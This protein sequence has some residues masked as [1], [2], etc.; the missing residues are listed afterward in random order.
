MPQKKKESLGGDKPGQEVQADH[1]LFLQAFEKPTQ[2]YRYLRS[3]NVLSPIFLQRTLY[4]MR[5]RMSRSHK[6]RMTFKLDGL[7]EKV[8][9]KSERQGER[10]ASY[11]NIAFTGFHDDKLEGVSGD[12][13]RVETFIVKMCHKKRKESSAPLMQVSV[14]TQDVSI[15]P[16]ESSGGGGGGGGRCYPTI[17]IPTHSFT[18]SNGHQVKSYVMVF[19]VTLVHDQENAGE[20]L[21]KRRRV[22][23]SSSQDAQDANIANNT[24]NTPNNNNNNNNN[25]T[26]A[27]QNGDASNGGV[28]STY[29]GE[30][31]MFDRHGRSLLTPGHYELVLELQAGADGDSL[32][33]CRSSPKKVAG[34][35][36]ISTLKLDGIFNHIPVLKF[37]LNWTNETSSPAPERP[38]LQPLKPLDVV[39]ANST[40]TKPRPQGVA[41]PE[42]PQLVLYQ[43]V[44]NNN[45]RQQTEARRDFHCPWCSLNCMALYSLLKHLKLCHARFSFTYVPHPK[46]ARIDVSLNECYD[47]S[48]AGNPQ[49]L[50]ALPAGFAF[51]RS[52]P[53]RR[54]PTTSVLVCRPKRP[55]PSLSEFLEQDDDFDLPRSYILGHNRLYHHT[56][57]CLPIQ[58]HE[59]DEDSEGEHDSEWVRQKTQ[60]MIDEFSDVNEGEKEVMKMWNLHV[61]KYNFVGDSQIPL[62]CSMFLETHG[63]ELLRKNLYRNFVLHM[64][65]LHDFGLIGTGVVYRCVL[66]LQGMMQDP[67]IQKQ[68]AAGWEEQRRSAKKVFPVHSGR[69]NMAIGG[70][71]GGVAAAVKQESSHTSTCSSPSSASSSSTSLTANSAWLSESKGSPSKSK[72]IVGHY[73]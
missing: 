53:T 40:S 62:A 38:R 58:P 46:G 22:S 50:V 6:N 14:G 3:R 42:A 33:L 55:K 26:T 5:G 35:E 21:M 61:M 15:N 47:G 73:E 16:T 41:S 71:R 43:F 39:L 69:S 68:L 24:A 64:I 70:G 13:A 12:V 7:L 72:F 19:R 17:S 59:L 63:A 30:L 52:G 25:N 66:Q 48:Y 44:Y 8:T 11:L 23:R 56:M 54:T 51:S 45:S 32:P 18:W 1:E 60:M 57:T 2:I 9:Q 29:C 27:T 49:D 31:V 67:S 20:P 34:W 37:T 10:P 65:S 36:T 28:G 4:Y